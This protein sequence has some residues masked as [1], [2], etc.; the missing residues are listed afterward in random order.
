M[1]FGLETGQRNAVAYREWIKKSFL[2]C[3][4]ETELPQHIRPNAPGDGRVV[5]P[6][7]SAC[8]ILK[9]AKKKQQRESPFTESEANRHSHDMTLTKE[10]LM[11]KPGFLSSILIA[12]SHGGSARNP[13]GKLQEIPGMISKY[14]TIMQA[15]QLSR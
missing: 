3:R 14:A 2:F 6:P 5:P 10:S 4:I 13:R 12:P 15:Y 1:I 9:N 8:G 11:V 7:V